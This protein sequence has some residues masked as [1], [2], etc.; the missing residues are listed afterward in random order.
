M[1]FRD[2]NIY[3]PFQIVMTDKS[4]LSYCCESCFF[5]FVQL[6]QQTQYEE[7]SEERAGT[8]SSAESLQAKGFHKHGTSGKVGTMLYG[9][10][11]RRMRA[12]RNAVKTNNPDPISYQQDS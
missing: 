2:L 8:A 6:E 5:T 1:I 11:W 9:A 7:C 10:E 4:E 12:I 3:S